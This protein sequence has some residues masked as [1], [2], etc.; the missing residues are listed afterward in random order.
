[1]WWHDDVPNHCCIRSCK[2]QFIILQWWKWGVPKQALK[3]EVVP[4]QPVCWETQILN[5]KTKRSYIKKYVVVKKIR[6]LVW[7]WDTRRR[8]MEGV[9]DKSSSF[10]CHRGAHY[11]KIKKTRGKSLL[12]LW[13]TYHFSSRLRATLNLC[14][15]Y[16][17]I[18][19]ALAI[20]LEHKHK[21]FETNRTKIKGGCQSGRKVVTGNPQ[22]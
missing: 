2:I 22:F 11:T 21:K 17:K 3:W 19:W 1:M 9:H 20:L 14:L 16:F 15:I 8:N 12:D 13:V 7:F 6:F 4:D 18:T 10:S 5:L